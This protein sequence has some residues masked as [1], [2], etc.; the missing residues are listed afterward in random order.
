MKKNRVKKFRDTVLLREWVTYR[1]GQK[2]SEAEISLDSR[3]V[4]RRGQ[5]DSWAVCK[6]ESYRV[7]KHDSKTVEP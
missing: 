5:V 7:G 3:I 4:K 6:G 1:K 2:D